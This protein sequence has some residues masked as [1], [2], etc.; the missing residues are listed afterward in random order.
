[1]PGRPGI[2]GWHH[3]LGR[4]S[5]RTLACSSG[6]FGWGPERM[7]QVLTN[8]G[9]PSTNSVTVGGHEK[10][11]PCRLVA[12]HLYSAAPISFFETLFKTFEKFLR[13]INSHG[14]HFGCALPRRDVFSLKR[15][16][17]SRFAG[18]AAGGHRTRPKTGKPPKRNNINS[19]ANATSR[20]Q[21]VFFLCPWCFC[22]FDPKIR[23]S[24]FFRKNQ[25][26]QNT[27]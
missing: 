14:W 8:F 4:S 13:R 5:P 23:F 24:A 15:P 19:R 11:T 20:A 21:H 12:W 7:V 18:K 6:L 2:I 1:M 9:F 10:A 17:P 22:F 26:G 27:L 3:R 16:I 25:K